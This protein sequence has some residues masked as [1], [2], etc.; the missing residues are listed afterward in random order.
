MRLLRCLLPTL[1]AF[2]LLAPA[3]VWG[4]NEVR[5]REDADALLKPENKPKLD[6]LKLAFKTL[7]DSNDPTKNMKF[8]ANI[9]GAPTGETATGPCEHNSELIWPWHRAYLYQFESALRESS[10]P[11][12]ANVTLPY[13][14]WAAPP[15]GQRFP[16]IF[17]EPGSP[18]N[19]QFRT[20]TASSSPVPSNIEDQLL[21]VPLWVDF[22]GVAKADEPGPGAME[23]LAHNS[24]HGFIGGHNNSTARSARDPIFWAHHANLD[25]IWSDW[26]AKNGEQPVG[27]MEPIRGLPGTVV[28]D[29]LDVSMK[30][31][32]GPKATPAPNLQPHFFASRLT[33]R[34]NEPAWTKPIEVPAFGANYRLILRLKKVQPPEVSKDFLAVDVYLHAKSESLDKGD[35][36]FRK[37]YLLTHFA[38]W[39]SSHAPHGAA[40]KH[41]AGIDVLLDVTE[42]A[43]EILKKTG[44][45]ELTLSMQF[46]GKVRDGEAEHIAHD[47]DAGVRLQ[48]V[49]FVVKPIPAKKKDTK[50]N[51]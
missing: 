4:Q 37:D 30:Y 27:L 2:I 41:G 34:K 40:P 11:E 26:T 12:T 1:F 8:W 47:G 32:Y 29:W 50:P 25:R 5:I 21:A 51:Q 13:W 39:N 19:Y 46:I 44:D 48:Q 7:Q 35:D 43:R 6:A 33:L 36:A 3:A 28:N 22:G 31:K 42:R 16:K 23:L 49:D 9:H 18:L 45:K 38:L 17:E 14:N 24:V 15:S 10:P 20:T